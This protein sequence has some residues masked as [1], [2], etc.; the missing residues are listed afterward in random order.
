MFEALANRLVYDGLG[1]PAGTALADALHFFVMDV[2]KIF[3]MLVIIISLVRET[4]SFRAGRDSTSVLADPVLAPLLWL[5]Y[6][7]LETVPLLL[8]AQT[9][10]DER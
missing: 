1:L 7:R 8:A 5:S 4:P 2:T 6:L 9:T 3:A 10:I